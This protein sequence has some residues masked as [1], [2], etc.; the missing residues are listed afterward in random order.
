MITFSSSALENLIAPGIT[1]FTLASIP[2]ITKEFDQYPYWLS[3]HFLNKLNVLLGAPDF[4]SPVKQIVMNIVRCGFFTFQEYDH[5][6]ETTSKYLHDLNPSNPSVNGYHQITHHWK[7]LMNEYLTCTDLCNEFNSR[8]GASIRVFEE[9]DGSKECRFYEIG[10]TTK[11]FRGKMRRNKIKDQHTIPFWLTNTGIESIDASISYAEIGEIVRDIGTLT[12]E[13]VA[14][15]EF[16]KKYVPEN[17]R[18]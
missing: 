16:I 2:D 7:C 12:E 15:L 14:P 9:N 10:N 8:L 5:A 18:E 13:V 4:K 1:Q 3:S 6:R 17:E 11:H